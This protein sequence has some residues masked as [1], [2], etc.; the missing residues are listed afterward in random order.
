MISALV[1][2]WYHGKEAPRAPN[3][4]ELC[5]KARTSEN[6]AT[7]DLQPYDWHLA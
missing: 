3:D 2:V 4:P 1:W 6:R 7:P 5:K